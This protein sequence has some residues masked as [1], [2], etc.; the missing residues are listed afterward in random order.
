MGGTI[1]GRALPPGCGGAI[2]SI[3]IDVLPEHTF[4]EDVEWLK[5]E[6]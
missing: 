5:D 6:G 2:E 1:G 3:F 4:F